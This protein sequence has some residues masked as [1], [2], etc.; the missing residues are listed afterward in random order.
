[1]PS[2][3]GRAADFTVIDTDRIAGIVEA[4]EDAE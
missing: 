3:E 1:M 2:D 4:D